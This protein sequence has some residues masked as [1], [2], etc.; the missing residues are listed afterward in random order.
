M[1]RWFFLRELFCWCPEKNSYPNVVLP[2]LMTL[3]I[4][5]SWSGRKDS[6]WLNCFSKFP[7]ELLMYS[8]PRS[9]TRCPRI[10]AFSSF[11]CVPG[12]FWNN[13]R[14]ALNRTG[15]H[16]RRAFLNP[17]FS[18]ALCRAVPSPR[19]KHAKASK[20]SCFRWD[21]SLCRTSRFAFPILAKYCLQLP[22]A[23]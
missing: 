17:K 11:I 14:Q 1:G 19:T 3:L 8:P 2:L 22:V 18:P 15:C 9:Q 13:T 6:H 16:C 20:S 12:I 10:S 4:A 21:D 7:P 23:A 5:S